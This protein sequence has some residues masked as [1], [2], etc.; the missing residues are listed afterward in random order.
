MGNSINLPQ[1]NRMNG[2]EG[3]Q[4]AREPSASRLNA[5]SNDQ[6]S[7]KKQ[8]VQAQIAK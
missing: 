3:K 2:Q 8:S 4:L 1:N 7:Y 6:G 5:L